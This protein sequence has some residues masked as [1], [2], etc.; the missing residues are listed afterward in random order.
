MCA[1]LD[2][3]AWLVYNTEWHNIWHENSHWYKELTRDVC[4]SILVVCGMHTISIVP[5]VLMVSDHFEVFHKWSQIH[6]RALNEFTGLPNW[7]SP[8]LLQTSDWL[9]PRC[10][11]FLFSVL[12]MVSIYTK[13]FLYVVWRTKLEW[14]VSKGMLSKLVVQLWDNLS[15]CVDIK[16]CLLITLVKKIILYAISIHTWFR[17]LIFSCISSAPCSGSCT[18]N[19]KISLLEK[20]L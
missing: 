10:F 11:P 18:A 19:E 4:K 16:F 14:I 15:L 7:C 1:S 20:T 17:D 8:R 9:F 12:C 5:Q 2:F 3:S 6:F 13:K